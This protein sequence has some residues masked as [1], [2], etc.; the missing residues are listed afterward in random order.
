MK[1]L[2]SSREKRYQNVENLIA[3]IDA[4]R[5][6]FATQAE[7]VSLFMQLRLLYRRN[8]NICLLA[9]LLLTAIFTLSFYFVNSVRDKERAT[10]LALKNLKNEKKLTSEIAKDASFIYMRRGVKF[11]LRDDFTKA[12]KQLKMAL[13]LHPRNHEALAYM[14][15]IELIRQQFPEARKYFKPSK[16]FADLINFCQSMEGMDL[17][18]LLDIKS[19]YT[20]VH[21]YINQP[22][23]PLKSQLYKSVILNSNDLNTIQKDIAWLLSQENK[24]VNIRCKVSRISDGLYIDLSENK[25]L[26]DIR[27][28]AMFP[29]VQLKLTGSKVVHFSFR[30]AYPT[31]KKV[32]L[33]KRQFPTQQ[34]W[35]F[36][37]AKTIEQ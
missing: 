33:G 29:M 23:Y 26:H 5:Q 8:R 25:G 34:K 30:H 32:I 24:G 35:T 36:G 4:Y 37:K 10:T 11:Y 27:S 17:K 3:D 20:L 13:R 9:A 21:E 28:I 22:R 31:L 19:L 2:Q 7:D 6:G 14:G 18:K 1:S 15:R 16:N 12:I